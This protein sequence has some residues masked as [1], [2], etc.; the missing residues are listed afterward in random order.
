[1]TPELLKFAAMKASRVVWTP[2]HSGYL[3][4]PFELVII[5]IALF[6]SD[7]VLVVESETGT[8]VSLVGIRF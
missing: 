3:S 7:T 5:G 4:A 2:G 6:T 1:M 8:T